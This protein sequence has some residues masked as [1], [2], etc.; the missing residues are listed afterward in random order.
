MDAADRTDGDGDGRTESGGSVDLSPAQLAAVLSW[1]TG[2]CLV[3]VGFWVSGGI[4]CAL[5]LLGLW[6]LRQARA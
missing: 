5:A 2:L 3:L 1:I 4:A 6:A